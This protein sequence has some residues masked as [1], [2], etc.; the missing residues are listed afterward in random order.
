MTS[1]FWDITLID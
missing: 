1:S